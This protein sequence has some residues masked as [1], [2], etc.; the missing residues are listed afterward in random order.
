MVWREFVSLDDLSPLLPESAAAGLSLCSSFRKTVDQVTGAPPHLSHCNGAHSPADHSWRRTEARRVRQ[1][2]I[3]H[4]QIAPPDS[5]P[6]VFPTLGNS[7]AV[8]TLEFGRFSSA[9][10]LSTIRFVERWISFRTAQLSPAC[11]TTSDPGRAGRPQHSAEF[12]R[13]GPHACR[14]PGPLDGR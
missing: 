7:A 8:S 12:G 11:R 6:A 5:R 3:R 2:G 14:R 4:R 10:T 13:P 9:V 1:P